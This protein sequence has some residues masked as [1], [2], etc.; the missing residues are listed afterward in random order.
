MSKVG[1]LNKRMYEDVLFELNN[2]YESRLVGLYYYL[3]IS[4]DV[5][6]EY[7]KTEIE[8]VLNF[9]VKKRIKELE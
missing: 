9:N 6:V 3:D 4:E 2:R 5:S 8:R 1:K 7:L